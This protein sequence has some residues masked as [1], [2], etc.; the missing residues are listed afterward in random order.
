M[1]DT[2]IWQKQ[3]SFG[4]KQAIFFVPLCLASFPDRFDDRL[5]GNLLMV[6]TRFISETQKP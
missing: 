2:I 5:Q 6:T 4:Q 3:Q 1:R